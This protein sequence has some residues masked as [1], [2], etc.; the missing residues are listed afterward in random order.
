MA[1]TYL[2]AYAGAQTM[3][4]CLELLEPE[5]EERG[6]PL[7]LVLGDDT[8]VDTPWGLAKAYFDETLAFLDKNDGWNADGSMSREYN[9]VPFS[10]F[11]VKD[12]AGN[13]WTPYQPIN[14]PYKA[15]RLS[16]NLRL[17]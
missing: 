13:S 4:G 11:A 1:V 3:P 15:R 5:M 14:T 17:W 9:R 12:S 16:V 10:D 8:S 7:S 6:H 2:V